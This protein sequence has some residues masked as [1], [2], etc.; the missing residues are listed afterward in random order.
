MI[1]KKKCSRICEY[2]TEWYLNEKKK[3]FSWCKVV[4]SLWRQ[5]Y[6]AKI[7]VWGVVMKGWAVGLTNHS[8]YLARQFF[9]AELRP[10]CIRFC[11]FPNICDQK[12]WDKFI[13][14]CTWIYGT[15]AARRPYA[16]TCCTGKCSHPP[17]PNPV[18]TTQA[19]PT[20][21]PPT[22]PDGQ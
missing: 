5:N 1:L 18:A 2:L 11:V 17:P 19:L 3:I 4:T 22:S 15:A 12:I 21:P 6:I 14:F 10:R 9:L 7:W 20:R 8:S 16:Q 13:A